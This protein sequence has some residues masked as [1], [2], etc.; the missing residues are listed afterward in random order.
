MLAGHK[1][2]VADFLIKINWNGHSIEKGEQMSEMTR[3]DVTVKYTD[4]IVIP[5]EAGRL[6]VSEV[7][8]LEKARRGVGVTAVMTAQAIRKY[9]DVGPKDVNADTLESMGHQADDIDLVIADLEA[10]LNI[11][12]QANLIIDS[13]TNG[14]LRNVLAHVRSREKFDAGIVNHG[15]QLIEYF[16]TRHAP[17]KNDNNTTP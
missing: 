14:M 4:S 12:K 13:T 6:S 1:K 7:Q 17:P 5:P 11:F 2:A 9:P 16:K 15:P 3:G 8:A 10:L